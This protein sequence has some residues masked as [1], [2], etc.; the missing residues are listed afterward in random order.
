MNFSF[1]SSPPRCAA[2]VTGP[3]R[4]QARTQRSSL[5]HPSRLQAFTITELLVAVTILAFVV[6]G[7]VSANL[8]GLKMFRTSQN[9]LLASAG[10]RRALGK[11]T[12]EIRNANSLY[13]GNVSN[14]T[15]YALPDNVPQTGG[16]MLIYPST[17]QTQFIF[18]YLNPPDNTFRRSTSPSNKTTILAHSVTNTIVFSA[19][20]CLGNLLTNS[21]QMNRTFHLDLEFYHPKYFGV[22]AD[23]FK[24][25]ASVTRRLNNP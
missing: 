5:C 20:D 19:Q 17:N 2:R 6:T 15:F 18:Y 4:A 8:F 23:S 9:K 25:E 13:V 24:L 10:A 22:V 12:D 14:G 21:S 1:E 7:V 3:E 16:A 11:I